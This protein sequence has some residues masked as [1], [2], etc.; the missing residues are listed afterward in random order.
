M[1]EEQTEKV[2]RGKRGDIKTVHT[3]GT[4]RDAGFW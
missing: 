2:S 3:S 4:A 1:L